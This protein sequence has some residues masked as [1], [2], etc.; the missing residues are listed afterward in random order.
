ML[1][2][3]LFL[4]RV[5]AEPN[6]A[7]PYGLFVYAGIM[8]WTFFA[9][10]ISMAGVSVVNDQA[11][12]T[13]I[14]FPR[15]LIPISAVVTGLVDLAVSFCMLAVMM[16][17]YRIAPGR[18]LLMLPLLVALLA[19]AALGA[20]NLLS[21]LTVT[22]RDFRHVM[23]FMMQVWMF[24]TPSIYLQARSTLGAGTRFIT[25]LNPANGLI[26]NFRAAV[27]GL[28]F[29]TPSLMTASVVG[30]GLFLAGCFY[31]RRVER[32]FADII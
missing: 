18:G 28:P 8:P 4:R 21:A 6:A 15:L 7:V 22:Y 11:L 27:L 14:Y 32:T 10:S 23:T 25:M 5:A 31:F 1:V 16:A 19:V 17:I 3:T 13:K 30:V 24:A 2:F 12:I 26:T 29:D 9:N 20:G